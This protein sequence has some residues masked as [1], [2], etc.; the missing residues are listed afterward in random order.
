M[1]FLPD[2]FQLVGE[3]E[4]ADF[5]VSWTQAGCNFT[6]FGQVVAEVQRFGVVLAVVKDLRE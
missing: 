4:K 6:M 2:Q 5:L 1:Y 3:P